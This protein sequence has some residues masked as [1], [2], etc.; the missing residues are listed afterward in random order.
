MRSHGHVGLGCDKKKGYAAREKHRQD[1]ELCGEIFHDWDDILKE[2]NLQLQ[3]KENKRQTRL[4][5]A[6]NLK[7]IGN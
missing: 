4:Y 1:T 6:S 7:G 5:K 3:L 2:R